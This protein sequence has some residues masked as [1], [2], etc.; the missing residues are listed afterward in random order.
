MS[1]SE[2]K[3]DRIV[4][5]AGHLLVLGGPGSGKTHIAL[6]KAGARIQAESLAPWQSILFL[7]FARATVA[8]L[9]EKA[10]ELV[11]SEGRK[12]LELNTYHGF[13][14]NLLRS[15]GYLLQANRTI[16]LLPPPEAASHLSTF[17]KADRDTEKE[18]LFTDEGI[19]HFDLFARKAAQLLSRSERLCKIIC[20]AYPVIDLDEFQ[21]TNEDEWKMIQ[22]FGIHSHLIALADADQRI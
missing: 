13:A 7:S 12:Q 1:E 17:P 19:L 9:A 18:R 8:R 16:K 21:D 20:G 11:R 10:T 22:T 14:W 5:R 2:S 3:R 15:H 4:E 6:L